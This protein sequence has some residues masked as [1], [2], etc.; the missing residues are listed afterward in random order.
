MSMVTS[1]LK[2]PITVVVITMSLLIFAVLSAI[3]IPIDIFPKL[4][5]PTI[6]VIESYGGMSPQQME[7]FFATGLQNQFLYV[8]GVKNISSKSIQ[9]LT[10]VKIS[11]YESTNM[12]EAS[13]QV[14][15]QVNRAQS[16]FPPGALPPQ[17]IRYDASSLPVGELVLD[18]KS[19]NLKDIYDL[20]ATR[21]RPMFAT[22]P[23]LSAPP[24]F[25]SNARSIILSVDPDKLRS[26]NLTPDEVV[27][28]LAKFNVMSPSGNLRVGSMMY[29]TTMN[30]L[31]TN[32]ESFGN[33]PVITKNGVPI[34]VKDIARVT[35]AADITVDYALINGKRS[36]Y[37]PIVKT[38][39][40]STWSVVQD[41]KSKL[42]EMQ[43]LLPNDVKISYE[44]DQS[45]FVVNAVKSLMTEGSLGALLTG[46]MVLL[47]LRDWRSSLIV[48]ITIPV[49]ILIGVLLLSLFGQTINIMT[50]SGLALAIGILVDQATVTIENI[51]QHLEMGKSKRL[52]IYDACEEISFPLL[53]ILLCIL[54]VFAPSFMMNG[55]PKAMFLP[56]S[57][58]IGLTMIVSYVLAQ[59]LVPILSNWMIKAERYQHGHHGQIHAHAG[60]ALDRQEEIQINEHRQAETEH[61][62]DNDFFEKVKSR[63]IIIINALMPRKKVIIL[64]YLFSVIILAGIG[65]VVIGKDMMPKLNNGEF[66]IRL[67]EPVGTRLE[68]TEDKFK[69][70]LSIIN[71]TVNNHVKI[72]SGYIGLVPSSFGSSN[73]Y[74]FNTGTHEAVLQVNL[75]EDYKINMDELKDALRKNIAHE[76]PEMTITFEPIDMTEK[77]MSQGANTP[78]EVQ[79]AGK[80]MQQIEGYA[81]KVL[82]KLKKIPYLRD[83]QINQPLNYPVIAITLDRLKVAQLGLNVS[84]VARSVTASTSSSRFTLKNLWLDQNNSYT[85]QVQA[86]IP[87]YIM[88]SMDELKEIPLVKG[89]SSPTLA[90]VATFKQT[91]APGEYDRTG[92]RRFIT[93][94]ANIY[95]MDLGTATS[96]VQKALKTV[97]TPPKGLIATIGGMSDLLTDTLN[98]LQNGLGFAIL[99]IFLLLAAN[100]QSFKLSLTVLVT[101]PAVI[102]GSITALLLTGST[103]NLQSYMGMIMSTGVSVANAILIVTNGE[104]LRLEFKDATKAAITSASVRLR[105]ILMTSFA[106]IAGMIPMASG[107]GEAGEQSA[108]LGRAV[109]GGLFASTLAALFILP[110]VFAWVQNKTTYD[111]P[112]L[113][114]EE[115]TSIENLNTSHHEI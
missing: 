35:D 50:L 34:Y 12:A 91:T 83:V 11:F 20:A 15:L 70:V 28:A 71:K 45:V 52:A 38:A 17:V 97:G 72:T 61:P 74:V 101:I 24:P 6:Y 111:E 22:I 89:Q 51:H 92:P 32:S 53:L 59:T 96:D 1:A 66:Q 41:L 4:N 76:L 99:V 30:S 100:Y 27:D 5:L 3:N 23:G 78:I 80:D 82:A 86:Q 21:I 8:D 33:I 114:P 73:L 102:L 48:V 42:P 16:F 43:N 25:G 7:G 108:P 62:A 19:E 37:I 63:F 88:N 79:V 36:V 58:S 56:L 67:K 113:M 65:F 2:R 106:M 112:S 49:S 47:F 75:D 29:L 46:L 93:V 81:N 105:P 68:V 14:A 94:S 9:G 87:E 60:E 13:A 69:Q 107:M 98:S 84:D 40:A 31:I 57:M 109:I 90:D 115:K 55:V 18:S 110:L 10:I 64:V 39:S 95:K 44:F 85:Y 54:A 77:I 104:S 26:F 103:L